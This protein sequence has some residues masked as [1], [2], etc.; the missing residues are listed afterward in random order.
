MKKVKIGRE[1]IQ[2]QVHPRSLYVVLEDGRAAVLSY[3]SRG[4]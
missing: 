1:K 4:S 2:R 3:T